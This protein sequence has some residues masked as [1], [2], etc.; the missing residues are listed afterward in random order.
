MRSRRRAKDECERSTANPWCTGPSAGTIPIPL[1]ADVASPPS[2]RQRYYPV[3][4]TQ[5]TR[6]P[7]TARL[8]TF[9]CARATPP[10]GDAMGRS[11]TGP[12][13]VAFASG[14]GGSGLGSV[15]GAGGPGSVPETRLIRARRR[16]GGFWPW[17]D[18]ALSVIERAKVAVDRPDADR[19]RIPRTWCGSGK[20]GRSASARAWAGADPCA[21]ASVQAGG[22]AISPCAGVFSSFGPST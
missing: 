3:R 19:L 13:P 7:R 6:L 15:P 10:E 22:E 1:A 20:D 21:R 4:E 8:A 12:A 5:H 14:H 16:A 11:F 18:G 17:I 2:G 9:R